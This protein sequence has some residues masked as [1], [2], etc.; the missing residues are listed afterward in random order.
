MH[1]TLL[2]EKPP[3]HWAKLSVHEHPAV[4]PALRN[5]LS[6]F[7]MPAQMWRHGIHS[8]LELLR[9]RHPDSLDHMLAFVYLAYQ[10]VGILM[11]EVPAYTEIWEECFGDLAKYRRA[12]EEADRRDRDTWASVARM[13]YQSATQSDPT[14]CESMEDR[15]SR[16]LT[17]PDAVE[18]MRAFADTEASSSRYPLD[19]GQV[20]GSDYMRAE[21]RSELQAA[22]L[23]RECLSFVLDPIRFPGRST[24]QAE[25]QKKLVREAECK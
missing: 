10:M 18:K 8:F 24:T 20:D 6:G 13:W 15:L 2:H 16:V 17:D 11:E 5:I 4:S 14:A 22:L 3:V 19:S 7:T 12:I 9:H 25:A 23:S 1:R 21:S